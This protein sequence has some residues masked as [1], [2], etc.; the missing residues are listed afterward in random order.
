IA[1]A[2]P[3]NND[4]LTATT[5]KTDADG[6]PVVLTYNWSL[7]QN[8]STTLIHSTGPTSAT[9]D[10]LDLKTIGTAVHTGDV[11]TVSITPND[12]KINGAFA[13]STAIIANS[14]PTATVTI[15]PNNPVTQV[16]ASPVGADDD[17]DSVTFTFQWLRGTT[18]IPG[19]TN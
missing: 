7:T 5:T 6:D 18:P 2:S 10:T 12:G 15:V 19:E 1:P 4:V 17:G 13:S 3:N 9:T 14:A 11:I 8:G 16:T